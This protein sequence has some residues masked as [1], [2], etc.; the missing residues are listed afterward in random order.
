[1]NALI[2]TIM[3]ILRVIAEAYRRIL[4]L[5]HPEQPQNIEQ[6]QKPAS[7]EPQKNEP[8]IIRHGRGRRSRAQSPPTPPPAAQQPEVSS[9]TPKQSTPL[10]PEQQAEALF[11]KLDGESPAIENMTDIIRQRKILLQLQAELAAKK[12]DARAV[13]RMKR[14]NENL[15]RAAQFEERMQQYIQANQV[16][17]A[18]RKT[19]IENTLLQ[20]EQ[21]IRDLEQERE[22]I[23]RKRKPEDTARLEALE[24]NILDISMANEDL[25]GEKA[26]LLKA[27]TP[28]AQN[29]GRIS[30][31]ESSIQQNIRRIAEL[32]VERQNLLRTRDPATA[33][34]LREIS[35]TIQTLSS[36]NNEQSLATPDAA[37]DEHSRRQELDAKLKNNAAKIAELE[38]ERS[39]L[40]KTD[41]AIAQKRLKE[42]ENTLRSLKADQE[43]LL[44]E[45]SMIVKALTPT[46]RPPLLGQDQM[47]H[48]SAFDDHKRE[49]IIKARREAE[50]R[51]QVITE[52]RT[53]AK[54]RAEQEATILRKRAAEIEAQREANIRAKLEGGTKP[55]LTDF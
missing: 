7:S 13:E 20:N 54:E 42:I 28:A 30:D 23:L 35:E 18:Q 38:Q 39:E 52:K 40:L 19:E 29:A 9:A 24:K 34:R 44:R 37:S 11:A 3:R 15:A 8:P 16:R 17:A 48:L 14:I 51:E 21:K 22:H 12:S 36:Q 31:L 33:Q 46:P 27:T 53:R 41:D 5:T 26:I 55:S 49:A 25:I 2:A 47:M 45:R 43:N 4:Q 32:E 10:P 50:R 1:M 6:P